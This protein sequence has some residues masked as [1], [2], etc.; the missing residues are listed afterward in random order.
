MIWDIAIMDDDRLVICT[1]EGAFLSD[2]QLESPQK[3]DNVILP[4]GVGFLRDGTI[5]LACRFMDTINLFNK[6]G[7]FLR[8]FEAGDRKS[9]V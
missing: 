6:D 1:S 9:V 7:K 8:A 5:V 3:L 4:G 2:A